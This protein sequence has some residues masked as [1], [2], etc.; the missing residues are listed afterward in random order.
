ML[1]LLLGL[2][3]NGQ[4]VNIKDMRSRLIHWMQHGI[5]ELG[6]DGGYGLGSTVSK[7]LRRP[8]GGVYVSVV[9]TTRC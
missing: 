1:L 7:V 9:M 5:P 3:A 4:Q 6:D 2:L 8:G